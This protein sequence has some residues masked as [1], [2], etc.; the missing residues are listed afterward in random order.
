MSVSLYLSVV[1][2]FNTTFIL[3]PAMNSDKGKAKSGLKKVKETLLKMKLSCIGYTRKS[4]NFYT[5]PPPLPIVMKLG[6]NWIANFD[7]LVY[8]GNAEQHSL[9]AFPFIEKICYEQ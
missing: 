1:L 6:R 9:H 8:Y 7:L 4:I 3:Q 2:V 5:T